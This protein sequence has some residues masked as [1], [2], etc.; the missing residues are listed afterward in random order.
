MNVINMLKYYGR[1][2]VLPVSDIKKIVKEVIGQNKIVRITDFGSGTLFWTKWF[3]YELGVEVLAVD[4]LYATSHPKNYNENIT[5]FT[6]I[7]EV[8]DLENNRNKEKKA[9]FV[10]DVIHHLSIEFW[11]TLMLRIDIIYDVI[12]IRNYT[13][14]YN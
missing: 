9:L 11:Q 3:S 6:D 5:F 8:I 4:T 12:I 10:C 13:L 7:N 1:S 14:T 2:I